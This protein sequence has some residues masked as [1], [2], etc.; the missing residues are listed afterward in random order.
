MKIMFKPMTPYLPQPISKQL[1]EAGCKSETGM[2][3][4]RPVN[5]FGKPN[6][7]YFLQS[8]YC[9][10]GVCRDESH[11]HKLIPAFS[12]FSILLP[13]NAK[14]WWKKHKYSGGIGPFTS[15]DYCEDKTGKNEVCL[16]A[17]QYHSHKY[18]DLIQ[19]DT[20]LETLSNYLMETRG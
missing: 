6:G 3:W 4:T 9:N 17:W 7:K 15:C 16:K 2:W 8:E 11:N 18:L 1:E 20:D 10:E 12:I 19:S 5:D 14:K 13:E